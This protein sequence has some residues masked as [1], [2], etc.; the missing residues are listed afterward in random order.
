MLAVQVAVCNL[1][2]MSLS[3]F[4]TPERQFNFEQLEYVTGVVVRNLNK[5]ID[6][7]YYPVPEVSVVIVKFPQI[8]KIIALTV[9]SKIPIFHDKSNLVT[10][11]DFLF[12]GMFLSIFDIF[13]F[14]RYRK[15]FKL[16]QSVKTTVLQLLRHL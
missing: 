12:S 1:A 9:A 10:P 14:S 2:S 15:T 5:I 3:R 6:A 16:S 13:D 8:G 11:P 7:N 4:V